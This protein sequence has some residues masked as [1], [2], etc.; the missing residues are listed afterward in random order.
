M[1][2][3]ST[4]ILII[5]TTSAFATEESDKAICKQ[6]NDQ[7]ISKNPTFKIVGGTIYFT[8]THSGAHEV[9]CNQVNQFKALDEQLSNL[10]FDGS[11]VLS[12]DSKKNL[13]L[14]LENLKQF[15]ANLPEAQ[16]SKKSILKING[17][18]GYWTLNDFIKTAKNSNN[19]NNQKLIISI[20]NLRAKNLL[21]E[22]DIKKF[23]KD[24]S[25][26]PTPEKEIE[27]FQNMY[28]EALS[29]LRAKSICEALSNA[30]MSEDI[31]CEPHGVGT[32]ENA[33][34]VKYASYQAA[35]DNQGNWNT[36]L[37]RVTSQIVS[38]ATSETASVTESNSKQGILN[39]ENQTFFSHEQS[40]D[41]SENEAQE[42]RKYNDNLLRFFKDH[43]GE[44][45]HNCEQYKKND[46]SDKGLKEERLSFKNKQGQSF[47][48][49]KRKLI[50]L[51]AAV[52]K[53]V[54]QEE[55]HFPQGFL[56]SL[57]NATDVIITNGKISIGGIM[58]NISSEAQAA[59]VQSLQDGMSLPERL[60][61]ARK[62]AAPKSINLDD[63]DPALKNLVLANDAAATDLLL[64]RFNMCEDLF[65]SRK[66]NASKVSDTAQCTTPA[67]V[68]VQRGDKNIERDFTAPVAGDT[69]AQARPH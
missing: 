27:S 3:L 23:Y 69:Q 31:V 32:K 8:Q 50:P 29:L 10:N 34:I 12:A 68:N 59:I 62:S 57:P 41:I 36:L 53:P 37:R 5:I 1:K 17:H 30:K 7:F 52:E 11:D 21:S 65:I 63:L 18:T 47:S 67:C 45:F 22:A 64:Q 15:R 40:S 20:S 35:G 55:Y 19:P 44:D 39:I 66:H 54:D 14:I 9:K 33:A 4:I 2:F 38:E 6:Y 24:L 61:L 60:A 25:T 16:K 28:F 43:N 13:P 49:S 46:G 42:N 26:K 51:A 48:Y 58:L 56:T